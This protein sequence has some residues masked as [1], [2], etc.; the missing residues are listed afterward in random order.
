MLKMAQNSDQ[1]IILDNNNNKE[2]EK[3]LSKRD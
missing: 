1:N 3:L 2:T